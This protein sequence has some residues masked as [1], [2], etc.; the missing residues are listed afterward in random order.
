V[1][2]KNIL[3]CFEQAMPSAPA[4]AQTNVTASFIL[5]LVKSD[6]T[7]MFRMSESEIENTIGKIAHG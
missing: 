1:E 3:D 7:R 2:V 6:G 4:V 5:S